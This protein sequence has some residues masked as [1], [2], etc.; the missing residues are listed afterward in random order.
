MSWRDTSFLVWAALAAVLVGIEVVAR[1]GGRI[2]T[3]AA[4]VGALAARTPIRAA[5]ILG[6]MW[7]GWH[8]FAR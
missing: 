4:T 3:L 7:L 5:L 2:P 1:L 6:W 8:A